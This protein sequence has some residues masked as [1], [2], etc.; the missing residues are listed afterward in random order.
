MNEI[1]ISIF[2]LSGVFVCTPSSSGI[3]CSPCG[4][5]SHFRPATYCPGLQ[6]E[7]NITTK[8]QGLADKQPSIVTLTTHVAINT[9]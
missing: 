3:S 7:S 5:P 1:N 2:G 8:Y 4:K 6:S 9:V